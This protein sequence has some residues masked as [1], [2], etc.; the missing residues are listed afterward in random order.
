LFFV[1]VV[2]HSPDE[3]SGGV[4]QYTKN[5]GKWT[6]KVENRTRKSSWQWAKHAWLYS[7]LL[8]AVK[9]EHLAAWR[10][11]QRDFNFCS[12]P[13]WGVSQDLPKHCWV[14]KKPCRIAWKTGKHISSKREF[15]ASLV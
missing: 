6:G 3:H 10:S 12:I 7:D 11:Q 8:Q 13:Q 9:E 2:V 4:T 5:E 14:S 1:V 15:N